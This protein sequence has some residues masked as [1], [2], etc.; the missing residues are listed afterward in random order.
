MDKKI[1]KEMEKQLLQEKKKLEKELGE[2]AKKSKKDKN[3]YQANYLEIGSQDDDNAQEVTLYENRLSL[4]RELE[5]TLKEI[6]ESLSKIKK[7]TFGIC[8]D[9]GDLIPIARLKAYPSAKFCIKCKKKH[10]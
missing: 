10:I 8:E 9:C 1:L 5:N 2:I 4:E 3:D 6:N 7:G